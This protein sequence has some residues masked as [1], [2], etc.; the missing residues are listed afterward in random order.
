VEFPK[1][2]VSVNFHYEG[3]IYRGEWDLHQLEEVSLVPGGGWMAKPRGWS[4]EWSGVHRLSPLT[5]ASPPHVEA[6][7]PS[8]GS[9]CLKS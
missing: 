1:C 8:F 2:G 3:G 7:Q 5:R 9:N 6:W 4:A